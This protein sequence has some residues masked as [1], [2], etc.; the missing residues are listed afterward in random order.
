MPPFGLCSA[1]KLFTVLADTLE[2]VLRN[3]GISHVAHYLD[4]FVVLGR[5]DSKKCALNVQTLMQ[6]CDILGVSLAQGKTEGP[7]DC[8]E[9]FGHLNRHYSWISISSTTQASACS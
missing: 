5:P 3:F 2:W 9:I 7:I 8:P 4:D 1:P 6:T